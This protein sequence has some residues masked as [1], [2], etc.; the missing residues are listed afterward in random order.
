MQVTQLFIYP[1]K[2]LGGIEIKQSLVTQ[3]GLQYDRR[4]MLVD[5]HGVFLTQRTLH[6][7]A[8]FKLNLVKDG[9]VV[10]YDKNTIK[11]PFSYFKV[12]YNLPSSLY[13]LHSPFNIPFA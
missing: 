13:V 1:I 9:F 10:S 7:M 3:R 5:E 4:Y 11:I 12:L 6:K 8:L 2:S